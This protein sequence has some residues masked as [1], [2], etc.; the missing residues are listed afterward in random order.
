MVTR[1]L[2]ADSTVIT[3]LPN[4][5]ANWKQT[6]RLIIIISTFVFLIALAWA[7]VGVWFILPFAGLEVALLA[8][9]MYRGCYATYQKQMI[10]INRQFVIFEAGTYYPQRNLT[11]LRQDVAIMVNEAKLPFDN[12]QLHFYTPDTRFELGQFLNQADRKLT[13]YYLKQAGIFV[14]SDKWWQQ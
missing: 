10:T 2:L 3:L 11:F 6:R 14:Q 8:F 9:L 12:S 1:S 7:L 13:L 4:R 5:S